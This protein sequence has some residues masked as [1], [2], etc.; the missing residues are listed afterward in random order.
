MIENWIDALCA[1]WEVST[2]EA[3]KTVLSYRLF[4][5][6]E[7]PDALTI[8]PCALTIPKAVTYEYSASNS[9]ALYRGET[10]FHL[11][12]SNHK[13]ELPDIIRYYNR[14]IT[15][16]AADITLGGLVEYVLLA[17]T[18]SPESIV[19]PVTLQ[20]GSEEPHWGMVANW[21][22]K[23]NLTLVVA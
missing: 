9:Y 15:A 19:G 17:S 12:A 6:A 18:G 4:G 20:Y 8:F 16:I 10:E 7:F 5:K 22:V 11:S 2:G 23:E 3:Q 14:I 21:V 1:R 13:Y